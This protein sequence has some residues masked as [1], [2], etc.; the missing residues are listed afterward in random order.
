MYNN[1]QLNNCQKKKKKKRFL[2]EC[3]SPAEAKVLSVVILH[4]EQLP[5]NS[6]LSVFYSMPPFNQNNEWHFIGVID[7]NF[8]SQTCKKK[9]TK[10]GM[11]VFVCVCNNYCFFFIFFFLSLSLSWALF[12]KIKGIRHG[13][14]CLKL[15]II[16]LC[17]LVLV[18]K[19]MKNSKKCMN[20][21]RRRPLSRSTILRRRSAMIC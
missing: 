6:G 5:E 12:K 4:P 3:K 16:R 1:K 14:C 10:E 8:P 20:R 21:T 13:L 7:R 15:G 9:K 11:F 17:L 18:L 19:N 2:F